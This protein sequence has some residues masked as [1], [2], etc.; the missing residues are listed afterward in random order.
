[1]STSL[2]CFCCSIFHGKQEWQRGRNWSIQKFWGK[3]LTVELRHMS[4]KP[5]F[6]IKAPW[7]GNAP[8]NLF[9]NKIQ[10]TKTSQQPVAL[11]A[12]QC[13]ET[14][15][16]STKKWKIFSKSKDNLDAGDRSCNLRFLQ[17]WFHLENPINRWNMRQIG[18]FSIRRGSCVR[19]RM[20]NLCSELQGVRDGKQNNRLRNNWTFAMEA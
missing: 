20:E 8:I 12:F 18:S 15:V 16:K 19:T 3:H 2:E 4:G 11:S 9:S 7:N 10:I 6:P 5:G 17:N 1:M 14:S 13:H